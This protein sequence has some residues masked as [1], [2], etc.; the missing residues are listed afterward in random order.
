MNV[1]FGVAL[2]GLV[3]DARR[4]FVTPRIHAGG[5]MQQFEI[6]S[7][8]LPKVLRAVTELAKRSTTKPVRGR[9]ERV[10]FILLAAFAVCLAVGI[11]GAT[12][13]SRSVTDVGTLGG[14]FSRALAV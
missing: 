10:A 4:T 5:V 8:R 14:S 1:V 7:T 2:N 6:L 9:R 13:T 3:A 11:Q 12:A